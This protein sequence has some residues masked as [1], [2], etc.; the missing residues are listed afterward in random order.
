MGA[1]S[2]VRLAY[3]SNLLSDV[4]HIF[5]QA[6]FSLLRRQARDRYGIRKAKCGAVTFLQ[7]FGGAINLNIHMH[8]LILDG[9]YYLDKEQRVRFQ[10]LPKPSDYG[11]AVG[12]S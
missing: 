12:S 5:I 10:R 1:F 7:R 8:S 11:T 4:L 9:V 3:D 6:V 2:P